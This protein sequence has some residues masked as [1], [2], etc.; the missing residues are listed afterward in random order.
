[1]IPIYN[2]T[3][4]AYGVVDTTT[5]LVQSL[6][7]GMTEIALRMGPDDFYSML[8]NFGI[9]Q[10]TQV[11]L[12]GEESGNLSVPGDPNWSE[13]NLAT[14]SFG[15]GV[16]VTPLQMLTAVSAIANDGLM[17]QP[18]I[19]SQII[20]GE[21]VRNA[22]PSARR[23]L[24][25]QTANQVTDMMIQVVADP[26]GAPLAGIPGYTIAGKT[27][28]AE[29]PGPTGY[30]NGTSIVTF[31]GFFPAD[32][33]EVAVLVKLDRP[34]GYWGSQVAAPV[35]QRLAERLVI[36]MGIPDDVTRQQLVAQQGQ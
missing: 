18:R 13:S 2:S 35:F 7:I 28:T 24:S 36:L 9:G 12:P 34:A 26:N 23:V 11:D 27:G 20:D 29:I 30:E 32:D 19:V 5:A 16:A 6:N 3:R 10:R 25:A 17:M 4:Q 15:Q 31:V 8:Q 21:T 14:N 1:G 33:P 22:Q